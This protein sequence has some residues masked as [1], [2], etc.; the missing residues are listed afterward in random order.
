MVTTLC[1]ECQHTIEIIPNP[2]IGQKV[3]CLDCD[4]D[5]EVTW[6][7]PISLDY[8]EISEKNETISEH[9]DQ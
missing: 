8:L 5:F 2:Q 3:T 4:V 6:L 1:P 9:E 7:F